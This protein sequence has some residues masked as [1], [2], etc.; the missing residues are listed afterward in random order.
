MKIFSFLADLQE[1]NAALRAALGELVEVVNSCED[2]GLEL[3]GDVRVEVLA[4][5]ELLEQGGG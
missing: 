4:A 2:C 5:N 1:E 3:N